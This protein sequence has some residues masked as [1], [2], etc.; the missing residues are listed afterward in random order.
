MLRP[1]LRGAIAM[2]I[3][4][5]PAWSQ[6]P[7]GYYEVATTQ[8]PDSL[9]E[10]FAGG[11]FTVNVTRQV[12][13]ATERRLIERAEA[14]MPSPE[15]IA[16]STQGLDGEGWVAG[17]ADAAKLPGER[18]WWRE[19]DG[20]LLPVAVT[21]RAVLHYVER[22]RALSGQPNPFGRNNPGVL[23]RARMSYT[24]TVTAN[25]ATG[26]REVHLILTYE[27]FCGRLCAVLFTHSRVVEFDRDGQPVAVHGDGRPSVTVS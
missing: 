11:R 20:A 1:V 16:Q 23:H 13:D 24:A 22:V 15:V 6:L 27:L 2:L 25:T 5:T 12:A 8:L 3:G 9:H 14:L 4:S 19:W 17:F 26:R 18:W 10:V 21:G 7:A